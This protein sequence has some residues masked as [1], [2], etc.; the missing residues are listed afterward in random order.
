M[1]G[2]GGPNSRKGSLPSLTLSDWREEWVITEPVGWARG[3]DSSQVQ[4]AARVKVLRLAGR[5]GEKVKRQQEVV[6]Q[7]K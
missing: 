5:P 1:R 4:G 7:E 2:G 3:G 6:G